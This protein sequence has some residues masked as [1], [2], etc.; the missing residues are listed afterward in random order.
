MY[1]YCSR[2]HADH[3]QKFF[4]ASKQRGF[5]NSN[6]PPYVGIQHQRG[7]GIGNILG[8]VVKGVLSLF[9]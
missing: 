3:F 4:Q 8:A 1:R 6:I 9:S 2:D 7:Y 5:G